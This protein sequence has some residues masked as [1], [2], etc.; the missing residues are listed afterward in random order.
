MLM[1]RKTNN[2]FTLKLKHVFDLIFVVLGVVIVFP[3]F[4]GCVLLIL[5][6]M[7]RPV[8][9]KQQR[10]GYQERPFFL[11]KFR[12]MRNAYDAEGKLLPDGERLTWA[13]QFLRR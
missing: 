9:F 10:P 1:T 6:S 5:I 11:Y 8:F 7:G 13:G 3:V 2:L 12:T 4:L